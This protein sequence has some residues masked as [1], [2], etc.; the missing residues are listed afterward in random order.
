MGNRCRELFDEYND[1]GQK[2][3]AL[4]IN[5]NEEAIYCFIEDFVFK[6]CVNVLRHRN[7]LHQDGGTPEDNARELAYDLYVEFGKNDWHGLRTFKGKTL[8]ELGGFVRTSAGRILTRQSNEKNRMINPEA[9]TNPKNRELLTVLR[10]TEE[11]AG[12]LRKELGKGS[13]ATSDGSKA[14][15]L[16][17]IT[18]K[19]LEPGGM[20]QIQQ[21]AFRSMCIMGETFETAARYL[22]ISEKEVRDELARSQ[23]SIMRDF[24]ARF[25]FISIDEPVSGKTGQGDDELTV[26]DILA[27]DDRYSCE[28]H[29]SAF[30]YQER[31]SC[32]KELRQTTINSILPRLTPQQCLIF[33]LR[34]VLNKTP[35]NISKELGIT[36]SNINAQLSQARTRIRENRELLERVRETLNYDA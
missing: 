30:D 13:E 28:G 33:K 20:P 24:E 10:A 32:I 36:I 21:Q 5:S 4:V 31:D 27:D 1:K 19:A 35:E 29:R 18:L 25:R 3:A 16:E 14:M 34:Y 7:K 23:N 22:G 6:I 26:G 12:F 11:G 17:G 8:G 2:Y 15:R 9:G